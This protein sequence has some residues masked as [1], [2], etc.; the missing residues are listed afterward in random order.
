MPGLKALENLRT[1]G[2]VSDRPADPIRQGCLIRE[3]D[4][5]SNITPPS[6]FQFRASS[7]HVH[8]RPSYSTIL[9]LAFISSLVKCWNKFSLGP[10]K[11]AV[12]NS[13]I[14]QFYEPNDD[15]MRKTTLHKHL[16]KTVLSVV[17]EESSEELLSL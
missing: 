8:P 2:G 3:S 15:P 13:F 14:L 11:L 7:I 17:T 9:Y 16:L 6:L 10:F 4:V 12:S 5:F 1:K